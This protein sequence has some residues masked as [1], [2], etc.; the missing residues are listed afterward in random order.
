MEI[1]LPMELRSGKISLRLGKS[2]FNSV[3]VLLSKRSPYGEFNR[4]KTRENKSPFGNATIW[5]PF[6]N[7]S[8]WNCLSST[9]Q[10]VTIWKITMNSVNE[11]ILVLFDVIVNSCFRQMG[12]SPYHF[13]SSYTKSLSSIVPLC[14]LLRN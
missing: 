11:V 4:F 7:A 13:L 8:I 1:S 6:G 2:P 5:S 12:N 14:P 9:L 10:A 3:T